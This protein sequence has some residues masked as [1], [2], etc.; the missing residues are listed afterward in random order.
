MMIWSMASSRSA[1]SNP[2]RSH[3]QAKRPRRRNRP[4]RKP[5]A[6]RARKMQMVMNLMLPRRTLARTVTRRRAMKRTSLALAMTRSELPARRGWP[7]STRGE[8]STSWWR[9]ESQSTRVFIVLSSHYTCCSPERCLCCGPNSFFVVIVN[10]RCIVA[11]SAKDAARQAVV[12][13]KY[14]KKLNQMAVGT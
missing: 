12:M 4:K 8:T 5:R 1:D 13:T 10:C 3:R 11:I 2:V 9:S 6:R 7:H 14:E